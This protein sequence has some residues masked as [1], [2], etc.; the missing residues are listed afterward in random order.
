MVVGGEEKKKGR[1]RCIVAFATT[2]MQVF[3]VKAH[4]DITQQS[5]SQIIKRNLQARGCGQWPGIKAKGYL[6]FRLVK[7][8]MQC[9][10]AIKVPR[11]PFLGPFF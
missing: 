1:F 2:L 7:D 11:G 8:V 6:I 3:E 9:N 5:P 4:T 10:C